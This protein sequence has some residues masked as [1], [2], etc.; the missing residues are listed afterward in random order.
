MRVSRLFCWLT[1]RL[2]LKHRPQEQLSSAGA[3]SEKVSFRLMQEFAKEGIHFAL[4]GLLPESDR[5]EETQQ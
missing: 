5:L 2:S 3:F 1:E 4:P